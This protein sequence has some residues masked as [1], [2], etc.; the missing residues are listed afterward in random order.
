MRTTNA[1][2]LSTSPLILLHGALGSTQQLQRLKTVL[3]EDFKTYS[4]NFEGHGGRPSKGNFSMD[5]FAANIH[6]FMDDQQIDSAYFFGYSMGGYAALKFAA[7]HPQRVK[8]IVTYGTKF[9]WTPE[10]AGREVK[11]LDPQKILEK[12]P[13]FANYLEQLHAPNDWKELLKRTADMMIDLGTGKAFT[14]AQ[15]QAIK[16]PVLISIGDCDNMVSVS[17]SETAVASLSFGQ[18]KLVEQGVHPLEKNSAEQL[19]QNIITFIN[20]S[21]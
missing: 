18:L 8:K 2:Q 15:L 11:Q 3:S 4:F 12:V 7:T 6:E 16:T 5:V 9:N 10:S 21:N 19:A 1:A 14:S 13:R 20:S 17:E